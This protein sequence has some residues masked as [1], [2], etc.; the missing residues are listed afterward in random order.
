MSVDPDPAGDYIVRIRPI[1][2]T[3]NH[4]F[5]SLQETNDV[6][7]TKEKSRVLPSLRL[8]SINTL[9]VENETEYNI[10]R[11]INSS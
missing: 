5:S 4:R 7:N 11:D 9:R 2:R 3:P 10:E 1:V 8:T 6:I